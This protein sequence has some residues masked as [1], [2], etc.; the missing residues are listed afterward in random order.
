MNSKYSPVLD[1]LL[2]YGECQVGKEWQDYLASGLTA[3]QIPEL[4]EM[5]TDEEL[6]FGEPDSPEVWAPTHAWRALGQLRA[7]AAILPL[8]GLLYRIED[9]DDDWVGDELPIVFGMIGP[10]AIPALQDYLGNKFNRVFARVAAAAGLGEIGVRHPASRDQCVSVLTGQL[11]EFMGNDPTVNTFVVDALVELRAVESAPA[12]ARAFEADQVDVSIMGDWEEVQLR[13]GLL[14]ERQIPSQPRTRGSGN[15]DAVYDLN[16]KKKKEKA[17]R[18][19]AKKSR[20][21]N[22][23]R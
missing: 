10:K 5:A 18:K 11:E 3:E 2:A 21:K 7:E 1:P 23:K 12:M 6:Y 15:S 8:M 22:K 20:K 9:E 17:K 14:K 13:L 4:I 19:Q 16:P